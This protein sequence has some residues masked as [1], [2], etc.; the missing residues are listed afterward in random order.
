MN[1]KSTPENILNVRDLTVRFG[2]ENVLDHVTFDVE[3]GEFVGLIG[4]NG[5]GKTTLL[6]VLLRIIPSDEGSCTFANGVTVRY[7]PQ[8]YVLPDYVPISIREVIQMG[9]LTF[10]SVSDITKVL[11][12]VGLDKV[13]VSQNFHALSGG[14]K[15]RVVIARALVVQPDIILFDEPLSGVDHETKESIY[16]LLSK[17]NDDGMTIF[18]VSHDVGHVVD[19][20]DRVLCLDRTLHRGCHPVAFAKGKREEQEEKA[21][22]PMQCLVESK[23]QEQSKKPM[24]HHH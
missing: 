14:Q 16:R 6:K 9:S 22:I 4:P 3:R 23:P 19:A 17:L 7:V 2:G 18:F 12:Q 24:H 15:Q 8:Q 10:L 21:S 11:S 13:K 5:A 1:P 20:C